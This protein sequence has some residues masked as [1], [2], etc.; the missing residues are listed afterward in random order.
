MCNN[1]FFV[2]IKKFFFLERINKIRNRKVKFGKC[3]NWKNVSVGKY[4]GRKL[5]GLEEYRKVQR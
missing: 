2:C 4:E 5:Y 1:N 3:K